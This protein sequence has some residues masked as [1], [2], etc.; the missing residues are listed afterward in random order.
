MWGFEVYQIGGLFDC[1]WLIILRIFLIYTRP[2]QQNE[3]DACDGLNDL[4]QIN[5]HFPEDIVV[6]RLAELL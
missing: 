6:E 1:P 4:L 2:I 5:L 3:V